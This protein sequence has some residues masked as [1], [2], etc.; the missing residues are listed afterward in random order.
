MALCGHRF[1]FFGP[2][3]YLIFRRVETNSAYVYIAKEDGS[4]ERRIS[5]VPISILRNVS[6]DGLW[7]LV[8]RRV[9][10]PN[11]PIS[12]IFLSTNGES[13]RPLCT[14][15]CYTQ[16]AIGGGVLRVS[17]YIDENSAKP[18]TILIPLKSGHMIP[19]LPPGGLRTREDWNRIPGAVTLDSKISESGSSNIRDVAP[20]PRTS[21]YVYSKSSGR[22]NLYRIPLP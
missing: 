16:W 14:G 1:L 18:L 8:Q 5:N 21:L 6:P 4:E 7:V 3:G 2:E 19:E 12:E 13:E 15:S 9:S 17:N 11:S 10:A 20:G 22:R